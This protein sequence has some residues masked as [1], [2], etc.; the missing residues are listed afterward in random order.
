MSVQKVTLQS[1]VE[2]IVDWGKKSKCRDCGEKI[3][4]ATTV[5]DKF[6][7]ISCISKGGWKA[8]FDE[9]NK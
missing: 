2:V 9:C 1:G 3:I 7:P 4:W 8:H 5:N 6:I